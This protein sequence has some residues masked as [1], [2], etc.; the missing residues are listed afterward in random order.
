MATPHWKSLIRR[1]LCIIGILSSIVSSAIFA[2]REIF[3]E[4]GYMMVAALNMILA[5]V[6][7]CV[8][9][10]DASGPDV[11]ANHGG[12]GLVVGFC[13][14][15]T[16]IATKV[17]IVYCV[18][19]TIPGVAIGVTVGVCRSVMAE[20][21]TAQPA[22]DEAGKSVEETRGNDHHT[23]GS[24]ERIPLESHPSFD[25]RFRTDGGWS[26]AVESPED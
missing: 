21:G 7:V 19:A 20:S 6:C 11:V 9:L 5:T 1:V 13:I 16:F 14:G 25:E 8:L 26:E 10:L 24:Q 18:L 23:S 22:R 17:G 3:P 2:P 12:I 15:L 4:D